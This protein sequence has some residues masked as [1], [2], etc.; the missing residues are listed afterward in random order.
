MFSMLLGR[1]FQRRICS[2]FLYGLLTIVTI[3]VGIFVEH[4]LGLGSV[5]GGGNS[6]EQEAWTLF[7][8]DISHT[9]QLALTFTY[10]H[11]MDH[12]PNPHP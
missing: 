9:L 11:I 6:C 8:W 10:Q 7:W 5:P 1:I 2:S 12:H 3:I 4:F